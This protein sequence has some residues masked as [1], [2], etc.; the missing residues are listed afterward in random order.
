MAAG[1]PPGAVPQVDKPEGKTETQ[2]EEVRP[3]PV[4]LPVEAP[5][6]PEQRV[7]KPEEEKGGPPKITKKDRK[8]I[9]DAHRHLDSWERYRALTDTLDEA[10]DLVDLAD[11][12]A[13]FALII[14]GALNTVLFILA[15]RT[16]FFGSFPE[17]FRP[18]ITL[19]IGIYA[20]VAIYFFLQAIE[21]LRP[22]KSTPQIQYAGESGLEDYPMG[23]RF[24]EDILSRD[25][26]AFRRAWRE[27]R[28][29]QLNAELAIQVHAIA[30]INKAKYAALRRL[31]LGLQI[32][33]LMASALL[34]VSAYFTFG[35]ETPAGAAHPERGGKELASVLGTPQRITRSGAR[36]PS[37]VAFHPGLR[38]LFLVG[39]EGKLV[40][41][42]RDGSP[43]RSHDIRGNLED[44]AVHTPTGKL[45]LLSEKKAELIW[46]DPR[47]NEEQRRW[48]LAPEVALG[49]A[50]LD[51]NQGFEGLAFRA[52]PGMPGG[53]V[54]YLSHQRSPAA[55]VGIAF[56]PNLP[57]GPLGADVV[58]S[59]WELEGHKDL[60][61]VTYVRS[62]DRF[63][64][65]ADYENELLVVSGNGSVEAELAL[66][67]G[68]Q[69]GLCFD[70][71]GDL[72]VA[73]DQGGLLRFAGALH[74]LQAQLRG[75]APP[76]PAAGA[77]KRPAESRRVPPSDEWGR[78]GEGRSLAGGRPAIP[79]PSP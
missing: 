53:G 40:E 67:G 25:V 49:R 16:E 14:M 9:K 27:V 35:D 39:D 34:A 21:S 46:Y 28:M 71:D 50:P 5:A 77:P 17:S 29:G 57:N 43:I 2:K 36:E 33:T 11:H 22:R 54:F 74:A 18:G 3:A 68:Q 78:P 73:D 75:A 69:E 41:L 70:E 6:K 44:V 32:M 60:T 66:P 31:Y 58:V 38:H 59:R 63:L 48:H 13:R 19:F 79:R 42:D 37:G 62:I 64:V 51:K 4:A 20:V 8:R 26:E 45:L 76:F 30:N 61:A 15:A 10:S 12:K 1:D 55:I 65:I 56:D 72:W 52:D 47:S 23:L 24:Y 7:V